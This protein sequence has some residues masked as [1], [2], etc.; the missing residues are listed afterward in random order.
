MRDDDEVIAGFA[1]AGFA[2]LS[3]RSYCKQATIESLI[4]SED[5]NVKSLQFKAS[6]PSIQIIFVTETDDMPPIRSAVLHIVQH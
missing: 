2:K 5:L 1:V 4:T 6:L 3:K